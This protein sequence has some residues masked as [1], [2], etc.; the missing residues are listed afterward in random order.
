MSHYPFV[1]ILQ[2]RGLAGRFVIVDVTV[3]IPRSAIRPILFPSQHRPLYLINTM[4]VTNEKDFVLPIQ[5]F[6]RYPLL[7]DKRETA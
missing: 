2:A 3:R 7:P 5:I 1:L 4:G 6:E